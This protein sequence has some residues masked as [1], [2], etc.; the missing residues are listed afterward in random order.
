MQLLND[1]KDTYGPKQTYKT[2]KTNPSLQTQSLQFSND[3]ENEEELSQFLTH[4]ENIPANSHS[5]IPYDKTTSQKKKVNSL[6]SQLDQFT[7][8]AKDCLPVR[9]QLHRQ[10]MTTDSCDVSQSMCE[11]SLIQE[12]SGIGAKIKSV[13]IHNAI[14]LPHHIEVKSVTTQPEVKA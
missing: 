11:D 9:R 4:K 7:I 2:S 12:E 14:A 5:S 6:K 10:I 3:S 8:L 1:N 13:S